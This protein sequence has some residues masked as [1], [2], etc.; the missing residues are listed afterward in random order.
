M[1]MR[2]DWVADLPGQIQAAEKRVQALIAR[3]S[4][5]TGDELLEELSNA[6]EELRVALEELN[7][8]SHEILLVRDRAERERA[9]YADLFEFAPD[10]YLVTDTS[11]VIKE[12]NRSAVELLKPG[13]WAIAGRP[14]T[15]LI[16]QR[17]RELF[18]AHFER[19][20]RGPPGRRAQWE[21]RV[22]MPSVTAAFA[23]WSAMRFEASAGAASHIRWQIRDI[24]QQANAEADVFQWKQRYQTIAELSA[25]MALGAAKDDRGRLL[26]IWATPG[27]TRLTGWTLDDLRSQ[28]SIWHALAVKE[29][30]EV[31]N[32]ALERVLAG[33]QT[34]WTMRIV[35][36]AGGLL[37]LD[38]HARPALDL[39]NHVI[40]LICVARDVTTQRRT[41]QDLR[42]S[43]LRFRT[44]A[45]RARDIVF[46]IH[47]DPIPSF[48]YL[49]PSAETVLGLS[50]DALM[51]D[52]DLYW[53]VAHP[54]DRDAVRF[55]LTSPTPGTFPLI[56]RMLTPGGTP[57]WLEIFATQEEDDDGHPTSVVG[58]VRDVTARI[59][60]E[61]GLTAALASE[62][63]TIER[64]RDADDVRRTF[65]RTL[66]HDLRGP[67]AAIR[68]LSETAELLI[69]SGTLDRTV[70]MLQRIQSQTVHLA[71]IVND[72]LD[73]DRLET[74]S[75][76]L[77][78]TTTRID[79]L[80]RTLADNIDPGGRIDVSVPG[81]LTARVDGGLVTRVVGNLLS[82]AL[83]YA[84]AAA[85]LWVAAYKQGD[86]I[87]FVVENEGPA[88]PDAIKE[89]LFGDAV[90]SGGGGLGIGLSIAGRLTTLMGGTIWVEDRPGGGP[91]FRLLVPDGG[92]RPGTTGPPTEPDQP[93]DTM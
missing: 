66:S 1:S 27:L 63:D 32:T 9:R 61:R 53:A 57:R 17:D 93:S 22:G 71:S 74:G 45:D 59:E 76:V 36:R 67:L 72:L 89:T 25:D 28:P 48:D 83:R 33:H 64:L 30:Q 4:E 38:V 16:D 77:H 39:G 54:D 68:G 52:P 19:L 47:L 3:A 88:I 84:P 92:R 78:A 40:G 81:G 14:L 85:K 6:F 35:T 51:A 91:S 73:V 23:S 62:H 86:A 42:D 7:H 70:P 21:T 69:D 29:D 90:A 44:M 79:D 55:A 31:T 82:N 75:A 46:R 56:Y 13:V 50:R 43:E 37:S 87:L 2:G 60:T 8:R 80:V 58:I 11:G 10:G 18:T 49:S 24:T 12:A 15:S 65:I 26:P 20:L 5:A 41:E 34:S